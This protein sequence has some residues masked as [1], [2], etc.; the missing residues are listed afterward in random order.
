MTG[1]RRS[2]VP[3]VPSELIKTG[4]PRLSLAS[5]HGV[6]PRLAIGQDPPA[7]DHQNKTTMWTMPSTSPPTSPMR[8]GQRSCFSF[9]MAVPGAVLVR[10]ASVGGNRR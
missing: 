8:W 4:A 9:S 2:V 10:S 5:P 7:T 6:E 3:A 1:Q